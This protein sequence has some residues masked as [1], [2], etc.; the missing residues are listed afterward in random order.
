MRRA[1]PYGHDI[2][3]HL[4]TQLINLKWIAMLHLHAYAWVERS[5][6]S[7]NKPNGDDY[8]DQSDYLWRG[9]N[10]RTWRDPPDRFRRG[11]GCRAPDSPTER[12]GRR[13]DRRRPAAR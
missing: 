7:L 10:R 11:P 9:S 13:S 1:I 5:R 12:L 6:S 4:Q 2:C 8:E 3:A